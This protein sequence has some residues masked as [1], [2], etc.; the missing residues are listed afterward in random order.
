MNLNSRDNSNVNSKRVF[1]YLEVEVLRVFEYNGP[2]IKEYLYATLK[3]NSSQSLTTGKVFKPIF[4]Q[5]NWVITINNLG[6]LRSFLVCV[7]F[8]LS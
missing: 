1:L 5:L 7:E 3:S 8:E 6:L 4:L 2:V